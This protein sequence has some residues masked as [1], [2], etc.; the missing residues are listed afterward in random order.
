MGNRR[1]PILSYKNTPMTFESF[2][3]KEFF[4][5]GLCFVFS[6]GEVLRSLEVFL[7]DRQ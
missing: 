1:K 7:I 5:G 2:W 6:G 4:L 3:D